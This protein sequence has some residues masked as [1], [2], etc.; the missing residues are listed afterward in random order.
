MLPRM[1]TTKTLADRLLDAQVAYVIDRLT[2]DK[3]QETITRD[4]DDVLAIAVGLRI[5]TLLDPE[6]VKRIARRLVAAIPASVGATELVQA[7][8]DVVYAGPATPYAVGELVSREHVESLVDEALGARHLVKQGLDAVAESPLVAQVASRF[9]ARIVGDVL[10]A[11]RSVAEKI[12][13]VGSLMSFG[14]SAASK[15]MGA[16]DKQFE[17]LLGD[18]AGK[19]ATFAVRRLNKIILETMKDPTTRDAVLQVW[20]LYADQPVGSLSRFAQKEDAYRVVEIVQS[21]V[22]TGAATVH[23]EA[24]VDALVDAF[25]ERYG[26]HPVTTLLEEL[27]IS[28]DDLVTDVGALAPKI[29][30][31]AA[32]KGELE[33]LVRARLE[34]F[35]QSAEVTE[36]LG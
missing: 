36:L 1:A 23:A 7:A 30:G 12:P 22:A 26:E 9:V 25:F 16:A 17:Q 10:A 11:N 18:T 2:G 4:V 13:G 3:L 19:G 20:D 5:D 31:A 32:E 33:K 6:E 8:T 29:I 14:T 24:L 27:E 35:F 15:V 28:R 34:P 21:M